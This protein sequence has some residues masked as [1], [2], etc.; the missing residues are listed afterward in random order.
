[1]YARP[2]QRAEKRGP[3][4]PGWCFSPTRL[5][6]RHVKRRAPLICAIF[7]L[8]W[9]V[10]G[11]PASAAAESPLP[12]L[13][14]AA[15]VPRFRFD[16]GAPLLAPAGVAPD[17]TICV[18]TTDGY[19]HALAADGSYRWSY[20]VHGA[21][22]HRP[23]FAGALWYI[24]TSAE[25]VYAFT[26][27]GA[28]YWVFKP[29]SAVSSEL[30][31]DDSGLL[32]FVAADHFL[33]GV[34]AHGGVALRAAFGEVSAGP[35]ARADGA[36]WAMNQAG[37]VVRVHGQELRRFGPE[38]AP[39]LDFGEPDTLRDPEGHLWRVERVESGALEFSTTQ[40]AERTSF[41]LGSSPLLTPAWSS[42]GHYA[43]VSARSGLVMAVDPP[44][45][46]QAR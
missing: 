32:Y 40:A 31:A 43:V 3:R 22:L 5:K 20:S 2:V 4:G 6:P 46:R 34:T 29:P 18:G 37:N 7:A 27:E 19:I 33:Y 35:H 45:A 42:A 17:G 13:V 28:L 39:E 21:V 9:L 14:P 25:R 41:S 38:A 11:R 12:A 23:L 16:A 15:A 24:A 36:V 44:R 1:M 10:P 30:A 26:R 8:P